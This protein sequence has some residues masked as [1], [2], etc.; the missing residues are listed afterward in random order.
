MAFALVA[1]GC[2]GSGSDGET[3][4]SEP[5]RIPV[6]DQPLRWERE[7][8]AKWDGRG[9]MGAEPKPIFPDSPPPEFLAVIDPLEGIGTMAREGSTVTIQ[10]VGYLYDSQKKFD[11]SWE[12]GKPTTFKLGAGSQI[13]GWEE[14]IEEME[15]GDQREMV[16]PPD[17]AYGAK[18]VGE[19]PPNSTLVF[20][21][22]MLDVQG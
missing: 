4:A 5:F 3:T 17:L 6:G 18:R 11:S 19:I 7:V 20:V 15:I 13:E 10:Y 22:D 14:G 21:V 9:L 2:G 8:N 1:S 16:V 12:R